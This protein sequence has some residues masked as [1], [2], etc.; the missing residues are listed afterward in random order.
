MGHVVRPAVAI[1]AAGILGLLAPGPSNA[2]SGAAPQPQRAAVTSVAGYYPDVDRIVCEINED[3]A[4]HG[5]PALLISQ[6]AGDVAR[7]HAKDMSGQNKLTSVGSDGRDL[8][9]RLSDA[10]IFSSFVYEFMF[11]GYDHDGYF[12]DMATDPDPANEFHKAL[13]NSKVV[14]L[15]LGYEDRYWDVDL[16]GAHRGLTTRAASCGDSTTTA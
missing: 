11:Y 5:L 3:R 10:G 7:A 8:R 12:A 4:G 6:T 1:A 16:L 15:G 13:M 9:A 14:A 2:A